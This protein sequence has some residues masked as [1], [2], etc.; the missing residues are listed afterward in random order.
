[1]C[2]CVH[3]PRNCKSKNPH[4]IMT[5]MLLDTS[6]TVAITA[7][8]FAIS[9]STPRNPKQDGKITHGIAVIALLI[10][11]CCVNAG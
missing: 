2:L 6:S 1:M 5:G 11:A 9:Q 4:T 3:L 7:I 8:A 10:M